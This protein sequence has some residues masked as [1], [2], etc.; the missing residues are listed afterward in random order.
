MKICEQCG[1]ENEDT[2]EICVSCGAPLPEKKGKGLIIGLVCAIVA[3]I[4]VAAI[5]VALYYNSDG[6]VY[7]RAMNKGDSYY[8][9]S[10]YENALVYYEKALKALPEKEEVYIKMADTYEALGDTEAAVS[11]LQQGYDTIS[12]VRLELALNQITEISKSS[13]VSSDLITVEEAREICANVTLN[14]SVYKII[15]NYTYND[16]SRDYGIAGTSVNS[17]GQVVVELNGGSMTLYFY[18]TDENPDAVN[19]SQD[20][21]LSTS[22][23]TEVAINTLDVLFDGF[24]GGVTIEKLSELLGQTVSAVYNEDKEIYEIAFEYEEC[25]VTVETDSD[26]NILSASNTASVSPTEFEQEED[27]QDEEGGVEMSGYVTDAAT[28]SGIYGATLKFTQNG[29]EVETLTTAGDGY[30]ELDLPQGDYQV[31]VSLSGYIT[32]TFDFTIGKYD[33]YFYQNMTISPEMAEG[34]IRIVLE[35][36]ASPRDLDSHTEGTFSNGSAF[37][38]DF[39]NRSMGTNGTN[40]YATLDV[41][42]T[43]GNGMETTTIYDVSA[44][45]EFYIVNYSGESLTDWSGVTVKVYM[46][47]GLVDTFTGPSHDSGIMQWNVFT[48]SGG[49][50]HSV[51]TCE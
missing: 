32:E 24:E 11:I 34:V 14:T 38:V 39:T 33:N 47:D 48:Y 12:S 13:L 42:D 51:N 44:E 21:P 46:G 29:S 3:V 4:A 49:T 37:Y 16:Y 26:G 17:D 7:V 22:K 20:A 5:G 2:Q 41:D 40:Y 15:A 45:F 10:D 30:Y 25:S 27:E 6:Q 1:Y 23:P 28:G 31:E 36:G 9:L 8:N 50:I 18:N 35:W 19:E 43:S